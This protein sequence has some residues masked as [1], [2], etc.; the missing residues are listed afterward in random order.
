MP[1]PTPEET[2]AQ[3]AAYWNGPGAEMW[4]TRQARM[5]ASLAPVTRALLAH[6]AARPGE[7]VLDVGCGTGETVLALAE[8][9]GPGGHVTGIDISEPMLGLARTRCAGRPTI[10]LHLADA[11]VWRPAVPV[12]LLASRFGVMFFG[13]PVAAFRNLRAGLAPGGRVAFACWRVPA[14]N[15]WV[16][17]PR[18]AL[19]PH[20]PPAQPSDPGLPGQFAFGDA[21]RVADIL[22]QAGF[23]APTFTKLDFPMPIGRDLDEAVTRA[24]E[25]GATGRMFA[26]ATPAAQDTGR[27]ALRAALAP[28][29]TGPGPVTLPGAVWLVAAT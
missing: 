29:A 24:S 11:S 15:D 21:G 25:F 19:A 1:E 12:D 18:Q 13:D 26:E 28:F 23:T 10:D 20:L 27:A 14:E 22:T 5:D 17:I 4:V 6:A 8:A 2:H 7:R 3:Q 16:R 9:V